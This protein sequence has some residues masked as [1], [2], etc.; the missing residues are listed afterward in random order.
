VSARIAQPRACGGRA[1]R[2]GGGADTRARCLSL[3]AAPADSDSA[4]TRGFAALLVDGLRGAT[5]AQLAPARAAAP[6]RAPRRRAH[7][8]A[9]LA[10]SARR[11]ASRFA[12]ARASHARSR[13]RAPQLDPSLTSAFGFGAAVVPRSRANGFGAMVAAL[14]ARAAALALPGVALRPFPSLLVTRDGITP[15]GAY[16][17]AQA[18]YLAPDA[19]AVASLAALLREKKLGIVAHF[20]MDAEVQGVLTAAK[21]LWPHIHISDSLVMADSSVGMVRAGCEAIAVLGV[22]FMSE[23]VR[24]ILDDAGLRQV[25]VYRLSAEAIGC[26]LAEAA[27]DAK[28]YA[29]LDRAAAVPNSLHVVYINT[30][31]RTKAL[32]DAR[33][34]TITCTSSNVVNTVLTAAAQVPNINI[35]YGP[36][37]YMGG[38]LRALL[39]RLAA[40]SDA[41]VAAVHPGHTAASVAALLPRLRH[42][43]DGACAVHELFGA[44]VTAA[45]ARG[46]S[47]A[48]LTAHFEVPGEMFE[49]AMEARGRDMGVVG[50]T[51][52]I[53]D[54]INARTDEALAREQPAERL[55]FVLGTETGM[56]T[57][58]VDA[59]QRRLAA[60]PP[61]APRVEVEI[62][63]PV[64]ADAVAP[65]GSSAG[66]GGAKPGLLSG[67]AQLAIVP[68]PAAGEGCS[69]AGGC[70]SCPYMKMNSLAALQHVAERVGTPGAALLESYKPTAYADAAPR[71][72]S[73]AAAGC[74]PI[75]HMRDFQAAKRLS[76][77]LVAD[78]TTRNVKN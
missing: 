60:A 32:A 47:D 14:R 29:W 66:A 22:D 55:R 27:E 59:L 50:S 36:D 41:E 1:A 48:F 49:L 35:W 43:A 53:L 73:L 77:K 7:R 74:V 62:V 16:A 12:H 11:L 13:A 56:V 28:Y 38:N 52:N 68:G 6:P 25:P 45:V 17:V 18:R 63:F 64:A 61:S 39:G 69:T 33:V 3:S 20:Y 34:P 23:N 30:S 44:D 2:A 57:S 76:D 26:T 42:Y 8:A 24:A 37:A 78:I 5:P 15:Q 31:L 54:F 67:I 19:R 65:T 46:Y 4:V 58:I 70:A 40:S 9:A 75:L 71:G 21:A 72:G 10:P 51:Q